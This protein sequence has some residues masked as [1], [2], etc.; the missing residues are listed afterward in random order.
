[1]ISDKL[2]PQ[3]HVNM[4]IWDKSGNLIQEF[5]EKNL[6]VNTGK[7]SLALLL[8]DPASNEDKRITTIGFGTDLTSPSGTDTSLTGPF[9]KAL[10]GVSYSGTSIVFAYTLELSENNGMAIREFG[11]ISNDG[12]LFSRLVRSELIKTPDIRLTGTWTITL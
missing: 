12:T 6:I 5:H 10:D 9:T 8:G 4:K 11:L 7:Q 2:S 1:M 3:G